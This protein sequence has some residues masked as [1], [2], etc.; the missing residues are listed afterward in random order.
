MQ[1]DSA[2]GR[3]SV[4]MEIA[5]FLCGIGL[6]KISVPQRPF[7]IVTLANHSF[8]ALIVRHEFMEKETSAGKDELPTPLETLLIMVSSVTDALSQ[9]RRNKR[10]WLGRFGP[11]PILEDTQ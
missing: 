8:D 3:L 2:L 10:D 6:Q 9:M 1:Q 4:I 11:S 5:M 7:D